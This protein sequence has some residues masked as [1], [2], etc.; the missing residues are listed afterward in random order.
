MQLLMLKRELLKR[1]R[2]IK[3]SWRRRGKLLRLL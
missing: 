3:R 2:K 1:R